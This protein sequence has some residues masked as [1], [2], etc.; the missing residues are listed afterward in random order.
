MKYVAFGVALLLLGATASLAGSFP[1]PAIELIHD[2]TDEQ[3]TERALRGLLA[4]YDTARWTFTDKIEIDR[5]TLPHSH[6]VL[7]LNTGE[8]NDPASLLATYLHENIHWFLDAH[9]AATNAAI[10][11]L[12]AIYPDA[13]GGPPEGARDL[14]STYLHLITCWLENEAMK[15]V[16]GDGMAADVLARRTGYYTWIYRQVR[17]DPEAIGAIVRKHGLIPASG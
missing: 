17:D 16:A 15:D 9:E 14:Q 5:T 12:R 11:D 4:R 3:A 1:V 13:P 6:P 2:T 10:A 8:A 7:Q